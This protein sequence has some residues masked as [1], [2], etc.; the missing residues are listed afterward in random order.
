MNDKWMDRW[1]VG[2]MDEWVVGQMDEWMHGLWIMA[3]D[4]I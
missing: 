4:C 2:Q 3:Y 1:M